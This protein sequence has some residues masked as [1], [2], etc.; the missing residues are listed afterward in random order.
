MKG[1][2][3]VMLLIPAMVSAQELPPPRH[4]TGRAIALSETYT[5]TPTMTPTPTPTVTPTPD[6]CADCPAPD[7]WACIMWP[8]ACYQCWE[9]CGHPIATHTPTPIPSPT[10]T[11]TPPPPTPTPT[12][13]GPECELTTAAVEAIHLRAFYAHESS[14]LGSKWVSVTAPVTVPVG[15]LLR[16]CPC[17]GRPIGFE[18]VVTLAGGPVVVKAC[19]DTDPIYYGLLIFQDGFESGDTGRWSMVVP[20]PNMIFLDSFETGDTSRWDGGE[21]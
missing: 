13:Q 21:E 12:P 15:T 4:P 10:R 8:E 20:D 14:A 6:P 11:P 18:W 9:D 16:P 2:L 17:E 1:L 3:A 19:G 7:D 5:P